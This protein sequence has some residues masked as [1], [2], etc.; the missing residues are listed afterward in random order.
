MTW[1]PAQRRVKR[2][3]YDRLYKSG[4]A[5]NV[6]VDGARIVIPADVQRV[7]HSEPCFLCGT[8]RGCRHREVACA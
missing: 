4:P 1:T 3:E 7:E 2:R 5:S 6:R 8:A